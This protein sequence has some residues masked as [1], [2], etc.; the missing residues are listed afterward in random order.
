[1]ALLRARVGSSREVVQPCTDGTVFW[2]AVFAA[3]VQGSQAERSPNK[4]NS[5]SRN[6]QGELL[7]PSDLMSR[8]VR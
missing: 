3:R 7:S 6:G 8:C 1:M 4:V 2:R 5:R